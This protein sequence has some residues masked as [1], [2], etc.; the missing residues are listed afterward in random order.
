MDPIIDTVIRGLAGWVILTAFLILISNSTSRYALF[1]S[2]Q[3]L[4]LGVLVGFVAFA[5]GLDHLYVMAALIIV[6]KVIIVPWILKYTVNR[7]HLAEDKEPYKNYAFQVIVAGLLTILAFVLVQPILNLASAIAQELLPLSFAIILI[8]FFTLATK[9]K[10]NSQVMGL[11]VMENGIALAGISTTYGMPILIETVVLF[12]ILAA[13]VI[14]A[15]FLYRIC[16]NFSS[17][18]TIQMNT[19]RE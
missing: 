10:A 17:I 18:D 13:F 2:L 19:L 3:S 14:M 12:D 15:I 11:L 5:T 4:S 1:F 7:L 9:K 16:H 6:A 8:G